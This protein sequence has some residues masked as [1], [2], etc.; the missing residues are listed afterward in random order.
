LCLTE[1][2]KSEGISALQSGQVTV[3][4]SDI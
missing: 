2:Y 1:K 3:V 4:K